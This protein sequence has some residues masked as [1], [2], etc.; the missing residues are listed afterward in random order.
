MLFTY[1][2][3]NY[4]YLRLP[5][6]LEKSVCRCVEMKVWELTWN[7]SNCSR[8]AS[9]LFFFS[10]R[11][12]GKDSDAIEFTHAKHTYKKLQTHVGS[13]IVR[14]RTRSKNESAL[15]KLSAVTSQLFFD[16]I[17]RLW[18]IIYRYCI[19]KVDL[20]RNIL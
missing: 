15:F 1:L 2:Y 6:R 17:P 4:G 19:K 7:F 10:W 20:F 11:T 16:W 14:L 5:Q 3:W 12:R 8:S 9:R 18:F 13:F